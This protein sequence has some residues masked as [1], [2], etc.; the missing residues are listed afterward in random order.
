MILKEIRQEGGEKVDLNNDFAKTSK[1]YHRFLDAICELQKVDLKIMDQQEQTAFFLNI[2][3]VFL[4]Q[5]H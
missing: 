5:N 4:L 3:Q 2:Y 1:L